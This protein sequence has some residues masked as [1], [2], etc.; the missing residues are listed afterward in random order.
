MSISRRDFLKLSAFALAGFAARPLLRAHPL[1]DFPQAEKLGR[2]CYGRWELKAR[3]DYDSPTVDYAYDD[4]VLPWLREVVGRWPYRNTQRWVET[5]KGYIWGAYFQP[6]RNQPQTP[7]TEIPQTN[8][9]PGMWVEVTVPYVD[10]QMI[11]TPPAHPWFRDLYERGLPLRHYYS[12]ILWV[13]QMRTENDGRIL[14]RVNEKYGNRGDIFWADARAF[15]PLT[16]EELT[17]INPEAEEKRIEVDISPFRQTLSC[18]E[19]KR[20][21]YFCRV[22]TGKKAGSTPLGTFRIWRKLISIHMEGGTAVEGW[23]TNGVGWTNLFTSTGVAIH[24]T[25]WHNNFGEVESNGCVNVAPQDAQW[26]FRWTNP[27]VPYDP[28]EKTITDFTATP[29]TIK[30][31]E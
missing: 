28:G 24:S 29:I 13:D 7:V 23:D 16:A 19:G 14:Y 1:D 4:E 25:Y 6:V 18:Y 27:N 20:E 8:I 9:G 3:P 31:A 22:S 12:Q 21:V 2:V 30:Q 26:I 10:L 5:P 11:R 15:R 17:P